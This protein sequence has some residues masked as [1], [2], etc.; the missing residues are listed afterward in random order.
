MHRLYKLDGNNSIDLTPLVGTI[1]RRS[2]SNEVAEELSFPITSEDELKNDIVLEGDIIVLKNDDKTLW[3]GV[4]IS[5]TS[6]GRFSYEVQCFDFGWYL[7]KNEDIYQFNNTVS[8]NIKKILN[9]YAVSIGSVVDI[10]TTIKDIKRGSLIHIIK[11][12]IELAEKDQGKRYRYEMRED[13]FYLELL[14]T[15]PIT[16]KSSIVNNFD[17]DVTKYIKDPKI[18]TSID[19]LYNSIRVAGEEKN[20]IN[21][22]AGVEDAASIKKYGKIQ[23]LEFLSKDD[24]SKGPNI[25]TNQ[26]K[27]LNKLVQDISVELLGN[28]DCRANRVITIDEP[29]TGIKGNF[30]IKKCTHKI[31]PTSHTMQL[32]L[33]VI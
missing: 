3:K 17:E 12:M 9:D 19:G 22:I 29:V 24:K 2:T 21:Q 8:E 1:T 20:S 28:D 5:R 27:T 25:A 31:T 23:K 33:E 10:P 7:N 15:N 13:K 4:V 6:S 30:N 18:K 32:D 26:L 14:D 11:D 16:Y